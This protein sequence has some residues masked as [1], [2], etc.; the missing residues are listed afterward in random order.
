MSGGLQARI[1]VRRSD[2][3]T[4]DV[5]LEIPSGQTLALVGPNG[6]GKSTV[7]AALAGLLPLAEGRIELN[8]TVLD[9]PASGTFV[10]AQ[11]RRVGVVFQDGRLFPHL[12]A[13]QNVA[14]GA[15]CRGTPRREADAAAIEWL[16]R[17]ELSELASRRPG[18]LSGGQA[19]RVALARALAAAPDLLLM[20][21]PT[22]ALDVRSR[23]AMRQLL[24]EHLSAFSGPRLLITHDPAE[25]FALAD[26]ICVLEGGRLTQAGSADD[27]RM[28]PRSPWVAELAGSNLLTGIATEAG[29]EVE[30]VTLTTAQP[31]LRGPVRIS[32]RPNAISVHRSQPGGSPR[33]RWETTIAQL[34]DSGGSVRLLTSGPLPLMADVTPG[35]RAELG[36]EAGAAIWVSV[37]ATE[38]GVE[39]VEG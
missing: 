3:F 28:R 26:R 34:Q 20:D 6:A 12:T 16:R 5:D 7:A 8:G 32:I 30:G 37:K 29:V 2:A 4:L 21:E 14:F 36:L 1:V 9:D 10:T 33:N 35:A 22:A 23:A 13:V 27:L 39:A 15:R 24:A 11:E 19:Q 25:A 31:E 38:I 18:D 17:M